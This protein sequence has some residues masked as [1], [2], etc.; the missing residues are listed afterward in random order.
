MVFSPVTAIAAQNIEI[1]KINLGRLL[2]F[3]E[4]L[5]INRNQSCASCHEPPGFVDPENT[6]DPVNS[7]VSL[8][9]YPDLNGG[10]NTPSA[11]Y[12]LFSPAFYWDAIQASYVGGQFWDGRADTLTEQAKE[13]VL[14]PVEMAMPDQKSVLER[15][16][17]DM[18]ENSA[19]YIR[20][21]NRVYAV[22]LRD[23][24]LLN[25]DIY[26]NS[27]YGML[28]ES[29]AA[30]ETSAAFNKFSSK[31]DQWLAGLAQLSDIEQ[32]GL[33]LFNGKA[34]CSTCHSSGTQVS[35]DGKIIP[36]VFS[37]F[38]YE[39]IGI[40]K[41]TN[42]LIA[43]QPVDYGLGGREDIAAV[44]PQGAQLGKFKVM[45]LRN[46]AITAPYG[47]NGYFATLEEIVHFFNTRDVEAWPAS[48]VSQNMNT[49]QLGDLGLT[50]EEEAA[51]VAFLKTLT[52]GY[53]EPFNRFKH[54]AI[55]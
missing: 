39:N 40:P 24:E 13:P 45:P 9:S 32:Q 36:P 47:H 3:D 42:P 14:N 10:R 27:V 54:S 37:N 30:F 48:E 7:V 38:S 31:F 34:M 50:A 23:T 44:D 33:D 11:A 25:S 4:N 53:G 51:V 49:D 28:A 41:S 18:N 46:I 55:F 17:D 8:G 5:S 43:D 1:A 35:S 22:D 21:F 29:I 12:A 6:S 26:V 52:D 16:T 19:I 2:Y 15:L 20:L